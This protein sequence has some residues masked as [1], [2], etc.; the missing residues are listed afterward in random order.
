MVRVD[1]AERLDFSGSVRFHIFGE[2]KQ[3]ERKKKKRKG[4]KRNE[5]KRSEKKI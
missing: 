5:E 1:F 2:S 3:R 4:K